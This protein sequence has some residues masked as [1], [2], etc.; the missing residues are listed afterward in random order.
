MEDVEFNAMIGFQ[1]FCNEVFKK[2]NIDSLMP[3]GMPQSEWKFKKVEIIAEEIKN[4]R[5]YLGEQASARLEKYPANDKQD[6]E[7]RFENTIAQAMSNYQEKLSSYYY[8]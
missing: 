6:I 1:F 3:K 2:K 8:L 7:K 4:M 5:L